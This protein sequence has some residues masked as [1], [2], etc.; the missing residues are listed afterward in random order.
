MG[1]TL[2][3][4]DELSASAAITEIIS[5]YG[6]N[7]GEIT[8]TAQGGVEPYSYLWDAGTGSQTGQTA[9]GLADGTYAVTVTDANGCQAFASH[10]ITEPPLLV[11]VASVTSD[12]NGY[13]VSCYGAADGTAS[14]EITGGT[15]GYTIDW[16]DNAA[17]QSTE[18]ATGLAAGEYTVT[19]ADANGC[20]E[21]ATITVTEPP[22]LTLEACD[23]QTVYWGYPPAECATVSHN[24]ALGGV[25]PYSYLWSN[26]V[27][28]ESFEVCPTTSTTYTVTVTDDNGCTAVAETRVC[29]I[30][31]RCGKNLDK[32]EI[33]HYP[34]DNPANFIT[35]CV[36][37]ASV[38][39]HLAHGDLLAACGTIHECYDY[40]PAF[41]PVKTDYGLSLTVTPNPFARYATLSYSLDNDGAYSITLTDVT[42]RLIKV[43][44]SGTQK[45]GITTTLEID[46]ADLQAGIYMCVL[47]QTDGTIAT[48]KLVLQD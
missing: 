45:T 28:D 47:Q 13:G 32:V 39:S 4:P 15:P 41:M 36:G 6:Y 46:L 25:P 21:T 11:I 12:Y 18:E 5:C 9:T 27:T 44:N 16:G 14:V 37:L 40:T 19:V 7:D 1:M 35:E 8:V 23:N 43:L 3:Q 48:A 2:Y 34:P 10:E 33:C 20:T 24:A 17:N 42:G 38:A 22:Q 31:V 26:G 30:D 29:V